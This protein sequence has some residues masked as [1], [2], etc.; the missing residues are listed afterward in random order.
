MEWM[1]T[2]NKSIDYM[3]RHLLDNI[4]VEDVAKYVAVSSFYYQK[5][6]KIL[7]GYSVSEYLRNRRLYLAGLDLAK[8]NAKTKL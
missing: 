2:L 4:T 8:E 5:G 3:E 7:T 6:F 1:T